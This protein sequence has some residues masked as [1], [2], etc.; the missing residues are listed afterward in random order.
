[1]LVAHAQRTERLNL[2]L[3]AVAFALGRQA[4]QRLS[5]KLHMPTS[6]DTLLRLTWRTAAS[7]FDAPVVIGVDDWAKR[8]GRTYGTLVVDLAR[9]QA[10]DLLYCAINC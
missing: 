3:E 8:R 9:H 10:I 5:L 6:G 2:L 7:P 4:S 1:M